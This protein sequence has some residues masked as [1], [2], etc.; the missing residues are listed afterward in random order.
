MLRRILKKGFTLVELVIVIAVIAV[1]AAVLI[2]TFSRLVEKAQMSACLQAA[3]NAFTEV[4]ALDI[5]DGYLKDTETEYDEETVESLGYTYDTLKLDIKWKVK[6]DFNYTFTYY[7]KEKKIL[8]EYI[9]EN[10][11]GK[12]K[13]SID[14]EIVQGKCDHV[15]EII[16]AVEATCGTTGLTEGKKCSKC[17]EILLEQDEIPVNGAHSITYIAEQPATCTVD[18][19]TGYIGCS[20]CSYMISTPT[21]IPATGHTNEDMSEKA[22][23]LTA[24]KSGGIKCK[25]CG[26]ITEEPTPVDPLGHNYVGGKCTR[27]GNETL[28]YIDSSKFSYKENPDGTITLLEYIGDDP[29]VIIPSSITHI[30]EKAFYRNQRITQ[31]ILHDNI[32]SIG[33]SAFWECNNIYQITIPASV[34]EIGKD[35]FNYCSNLNIINVDENN[36]HF[37][38]IDGVL[39]TKGEEVELLYYP[40]GKTGSFVIPDGVTTISEN[41]FLCSKVTS[42]TIPASVKKIETYAF[43]TCSQ[44]TTLTIPGTVEIIEDSAFALSHIET[45]VIEEGVK[46]VGLHAFANTN[47]K[48]VTIPSNIIYELTEDGGIFN[49][50]KDVVDLTINVYTPSTSIATILKACGFQKINLTINNL[51]TIKKEHFEGTAYTHIISVNLPDA[52]VVEESAFYNSFYL[53]KIVLPN[54]ETI[55]ANAFNTCSVLTSVDMPKIQTIESQAFAYCEALETIKIAD[56]ATTIGDSAFANCDTLTIYC[57][58]ASKPSGWHDNWNPSDCKVLWN[59]EIN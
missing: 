46:K 5:A 15:E 25:V 1:L 47:C 2:P 4:Y 6:D 30:G 23:C 17:G 11:I 42:I 55:K 9:C 10:G 54:V 49:G 31:V 37:K 7:D 45:L 48:S 35:V 21:V 28:E 12:W 8:C 44:L 3:Q 33:S 56:T 24:G 36:E 39:F 16:P 32:K 59:Q 13:V 38:S 22:T 58:A 51:E 43:D 34:E 50:I 27:C 26:V 14:G 41:S 53:E 40:C 52:K 19:K 29:Q 20:N 18:G 57:E